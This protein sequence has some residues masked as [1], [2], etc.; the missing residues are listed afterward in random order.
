MKMTSALIVLAAAAALAGC[1]SNQEPSNFTEA[2]YTPVH[3][4][5][6]AAT[7]VTKSPKRGIAYDLATAADIQA[8][9]PGVS[10]WYNWGSSPNSGIPSN[11]V[12]AYGMDY[13]PML[14][15]FNFNKTNVESFIRAHPEIKY[16]LVLNEPNVSGQAFCVTGQPYCSPSQ[17]AALWPQYEAVAADTG[18]Q[19]VGPQITW[20]TETNYT[21][22]IAWLDAFYS[23]YESANGGRVPRIDYLGFHWYD[24]GLDSQ[25]TRLTK[26]GKPFWVTEFANWHSQND[27]AQI[28]TLA[29]QEAQ[30]QDMVN[31]CETRADVF[32]YAWYTGRVSP[33]PHFDSLLAGQG[34]LTALGQMYLT[35]P[36][37]G[38]AGTGTGS[39]MIDSGSTTAQGSYTA[40][41]G[42]TGGSTSSTT[43]A[44]TLSSG[45]T[46]TQAVYQTSRFGNFTYNLSGFNANSTHTVKLHF[47]EN[48]WPAA[49]KRVFNV[50][51]NNAVVLPNFDIYAQAG[52]EYTA[53]VKTVSAMAD[54][55]G[56]MAIQFATVTDN[57]QVNAIEIQ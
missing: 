38:G 13:Y 43:H 12:S 10:W 35:L 4:T 32:R 23:A 8:L 52:G 27:G 37:S 14:W 5:A 11:Y 2:K 44:I 33:D 41:T 57:A 25:L 36:F 19:I 48:Y 53:I 31:T 45:D 30:M 29:K 3:S 55:T 1:G 24:Y 34:Q 26:Y 18:V 49:G 17:A 22:P 56:H 54:G 28:D 51:I 47:S 40:D 42:A 46:A 7:A 9:S 15:N 6:A 50:S 20:G 16:L 39:V 21:D